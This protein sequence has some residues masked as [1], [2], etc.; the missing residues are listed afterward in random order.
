MDFSSISANNLNV[1]AR[2]QFVTGRPMKQGEATPV[3][4]VG[5]LSKY[6]LETSNL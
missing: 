6:L 1:E 3:V 2:V 4:L 5:V